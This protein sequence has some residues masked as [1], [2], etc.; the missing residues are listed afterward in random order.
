MASDPFRSEEAIEFTEENIGDFLL[1]IL[2][3][4]LY[5]RPDLIVREYLQNSHD[6]ICDWPDQP[7]P[8]RIDIQVAWPNIHIFD[9]GPGMDRDELLTAMSNLGKS[10]KNITASSGFMGI[11]KLAG[12]AMASRVEIHSSKYGV[13]EKNWVAFNADEMLTGIMERRLEGEHHSILETL[14]AHTRVNERPVKEAP[15]NHYTSVHLLDI[16]DDDREKVEDVEN[17]ARSIGLLAPVTQDPNFEHALEIGEMLKLMIPEHY[18]PIDI[19]VNGEPVY[20]PY[21]EGL[22]R[23]EKIHVIDDNGNILGFGWACL[24]VASERYKR[25]ISD[26]SLR[27]V[28][29]MQRGIAVGSRS[30]PEDMGLY[31]SVG[32]IIY[33][34][35]YCGELYITD[36]KIILSAD[37]TRVRQSLHTVEFI[38]KASK[39]F[40][41]LAKYAEQFSARDNAKVVVQDTVQA[42]AE[43]EKQV[44]SQGVTRDR[45]PKIISDLGK[46]QSN[47]DKKKKHVD[48]PEIK[49]QAENVE[50]KVEEI[51]D[52][53]IKAQEQNTPQEDDTLP[54]SEVI[55]NDTENVEDLA[56]EDLPEEKVIVLDIP[57][58]LDFSHREAHIYRTIMQAIADACGGRDSKEF[59]KLALSIETALINTFDTSEVSS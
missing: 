44:K 23:P 10:F 41:R 4:G 34:R 45:L 49:K 59:M 20:R 38:E 5:D 28:A 7:T 46:A 40:A 25:Q 15:E 19:F 33:F 21:V 30:L 32:N 6:A 14:N 43:I 39:E 12:L 55:G 29:L 24:N 50:R 2:T 3:D 52:L 56:K 47:I 42:V 57:E 31:S 11:G 13:A 37:R 16:H 53:L 36:P 18:R 54:L 1:H 17:F 26:D 48:K 22:G 9:N 27:G 35:W 51:L 58:R 8:E